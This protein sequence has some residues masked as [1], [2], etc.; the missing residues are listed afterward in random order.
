MKKRA[1]TLG[2][3]IH[4]EDSVAQAVKAFHRYLS[5]QSIPELVVR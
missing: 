2:Q 5:S 3:K 4:S 1:A